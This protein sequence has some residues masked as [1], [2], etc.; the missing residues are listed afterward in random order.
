VIR[1]VKPGNIIVVATPS[2]INRLM[3]RPLLVDTGDDDLNRQLCGFTRV[4]SGY[5]QRSVYRI[6]C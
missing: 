2:K 3:G 4:V 6:D 1:R 5:R